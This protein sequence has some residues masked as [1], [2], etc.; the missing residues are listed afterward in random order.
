MD[1]QTY[2]GQPIELGLKGKGPKYP[3]KENQVSHREG[4]KDK[5]EKHKNKT[6]QNKT[7]PKTLKAESRR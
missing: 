2:Q 5:G 3:T 1:R 6:K 7:N 4:V